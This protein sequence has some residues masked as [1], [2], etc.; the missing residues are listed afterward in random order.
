MTCDLVADIGGTHARFALSE[1]GRLVA[2]RD[3]A[4]ADFETAEGAIGAALEAL[5]R[6]VEAIGLAVAGAVDG[7]RAR[8]TNGTWGF[9][10]HALAARFG[11]R[12]VRL[13]ND[14]VAAAIGATSSPEEALRPLG[15]SPPLGPGVRAI[16]G[17]GTGLGMAVLQPSRGGWTAQ[18]S[19]GGHAPFAPNDALELELLSYLQAEL[20]H[21]SWERLVSG[22]GLVQVYRG[23]SAVWGAAPVLE[24]P[25]AIVRAAAEDLDPVSDQSL[26]CFCGMLGS[27]AASLMLTALAVGGVYIAGGL[28]RRLG[29]VLDTGPFRRRFEECTAAAGLGGEIATVLVASDEIGLLGAAEAARRAK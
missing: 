8:L 23:V 24:T 25:E 27:A 2:R 16:I 21:V 15:G 13:V 19:E 7:P 1:G 12:P 14:F 5:G 11:G 10:A 3:F 26:T 4:T 9:D 18:P 29:D 6:E 17:P 22:P 28:A 20:G